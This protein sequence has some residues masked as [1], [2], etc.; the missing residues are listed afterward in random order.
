MFLVVPVSAEKQC[1]AHV[2]LGGSEPGSQS[3]SD[4]AGGRLAAALTA[5]RRLLG[6]AVKWT[7]FC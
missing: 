4:V 7:L 3:S 1:L 2:G 6:E 5:E